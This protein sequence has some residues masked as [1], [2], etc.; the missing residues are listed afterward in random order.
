MSEDTCSHSRPAFASAPYG[1]LKDLGVKAQVR[2]YF[3]SLQEVCSFGVLERH[4]LDAHL[5]PGPRV[6]DLLDADGC[7]PSAAES[8]S[9]IRRAIA[10]I[11]AVND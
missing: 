7:S 11:L 6:L 5:F 10:Q 9:Q 2:Q 8:G 4:C 3:L 1:V